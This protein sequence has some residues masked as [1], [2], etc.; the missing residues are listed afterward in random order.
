MIVL[1]I[2]GWVLLSVLALIVLALCVRVRIRL[3]YSK[4][5][6]SVLLKWLFL[7]FKLYPAAKKEKKPKEK[8][9]EPEKPQEE[10]EKEKKEEKPKSKNNLLKTL[11]EAEGVD[12]LILLLQRLVGYT[13]TFF[14]NGLKGMVIDELFLEICCAKGDAAETAIYYG[15]VSAA[16]F[17]LLGALASKYRLKKYDVNVYPD[18][19][20]RFS[21]VSFVT[22]VHLTPMYLICITVAYAFK[23]LFGVAG[24]VAVKIY[25]ASKKKKSDRN[26]NTNS[27]EKSEVK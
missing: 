27:K 4:E 20:A 21:D 8:K 5:N 10:K 1:K 17:P 22:A 11:Y 3:E 2:I 19:L 26:D 23:L 7:K 25:G 24:Q 16:V 13:K 18:Y 6:T 9:P 12:G 15:E 14:A